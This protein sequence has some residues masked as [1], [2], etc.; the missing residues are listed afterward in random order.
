MYSLEHYTDFGCFAIPYSR[1]ET[2][3]IVIAADVGDMPTVKK[4]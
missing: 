3:R 1:V 2:N 4:L